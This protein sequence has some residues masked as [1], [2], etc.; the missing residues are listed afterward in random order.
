M[1]GALPPLKGNAYYSMGLARA[2]ANRVTVDFIAFKKLYPEFLYS[3][4]VSDRDPH[5]VVAETD[6]L[7]IRKLINYGFI[8]QLKMEI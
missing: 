8:L 4:G 3:G 6:S 2:M 7:R 1:V 5:F